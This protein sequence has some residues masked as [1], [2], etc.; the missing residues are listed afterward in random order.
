MFQNVVGVFDGMVVKIRLNGFLVDTIVFS[1]EYVPDPNVHLNI[2]LNSYDY[3]Q[4]WTG[5]IGRGT[6]IQ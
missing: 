1:G 6:V 5:L 3:G 4:P 2:G